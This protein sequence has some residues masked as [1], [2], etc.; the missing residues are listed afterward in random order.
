MSKF[1]ERITDV[2]LGAKGRGDAS[3]I[4][5][6]KKKKRKVSGWLKPMEK[7]DRRI[8]EATVAFGNEL[9]SRHERSNKKRR[10]GW[11]RDAPLNVLRAQRKAIK[12][13]IKV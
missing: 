3:T 2:E 4:Y 1:V 13:L 8:A 12:K 5:K 6:A 11:L 9:L 7:R 10:N